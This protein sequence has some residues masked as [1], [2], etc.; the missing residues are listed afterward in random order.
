MWSIEIGL[1]FIEYN[2]KNSSL[3]LWKSTLQMNLLN[4]WILKTADLDVVCFSVKFFAKKI[5][6]NMCSKP[7]LPYSV[8]DEILSQVYLFH[9]FELD[10]INVNEWKYIRMCPCDKTA[11]D[12]RDWIFICFRASSFFFQSCLFRDSAY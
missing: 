2:S 8:T 11:F 4:F 9:L 5:D 12:P 3:D 6:Q 1:H 10:Y 7:I